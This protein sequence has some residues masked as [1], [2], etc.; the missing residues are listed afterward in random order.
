VPSIAAYFKNGVV[1]SGRVINVA[2]DSQFTTGWLTQAYMPLGERFAARIGYAQAPEVINGITLDTE[3]IFGGLSVKLVEG[4]ELSFNYSK[5][6][7][8]AAFDR[9]GFNVG[10][11]FRR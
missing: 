11:T 10:L 3:S 7:R 5:D 8:E 9:E 4:V 1:L 6:D 2:Q